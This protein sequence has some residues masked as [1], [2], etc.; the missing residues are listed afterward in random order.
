MLKVRSNIGSFSQKLFRAAAAPVVAFFILM[1]AVSASTHTVETT[2][3]EA[4]LRKS[5]Y[6]VCQPAV[7]VTSL[8]DSGSGSLRQA[9]IDV[10]EG[11]T[12]TF[13]VTGTI[14]ITS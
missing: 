6:L 2:A 7:T 10:C 14:G 13:A 11:G 8:L 12:I 9:V 5:S 1:G 3:R 4:S